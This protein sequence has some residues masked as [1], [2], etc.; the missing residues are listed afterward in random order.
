MKPKKY[1]M[2]KEPESVK[3]F[4]KLLTEPVE[5]NTI[6]T[7]IDQFKALN[8]EKQKELTTST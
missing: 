3:K 7:Q 1:N 6:D 4:V 8:D 2:K 5:Q